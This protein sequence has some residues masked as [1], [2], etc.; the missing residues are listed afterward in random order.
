M[1]HSVEAQEALLGQWTGPHGVDNL[2]NK[3]HGSPCVE[4]SLRTRCG[5]AWH[6]YWDA[7]DGSGLRAPEVL[8]LPWRGPWEDSAFQSCTE[9]HDVMEGVR[10]LRSQE[11]PT[12]WVISG[13]LTGKE[14]ESLV[15]AGATDWVWRTNG[16]PESHKGMLAAVRS[17]LD[18]QRSWPEQV[19]CRF[20][21][22][23]SGALAAKQAHRWVGLAHAMGI[24][25]VVLKGSGLEPSF[26]DACTRRYT[27]MQVESLD[28]G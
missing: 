18:A 8:R 15:A 21:W 14:V 12:R 17:V 26:W 16:E 4:C 2:G 3:R 20:V 9:I 11:A 6:A 7:R 23:I 5:G 25:R 1:T 22:W 13:E 28:G 10:T 27:G 19:R 24:S